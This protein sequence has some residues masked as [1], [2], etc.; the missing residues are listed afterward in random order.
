[1]GDLG[2]CDMSK[3]LFAV[4]GIAASLL[5]SGYATGAEASL[6]DLLNPQRAQNAKMERALSG[7][8]GQPLSSFIA[9]HGDPSDSVELS[10]T[11][12]SFRWHLT[13]Q[14]PGAVIPMYGMLGVMPSRQLVCDITLRASKLISDEDKPRFW[15]IDSV[16]WQGNC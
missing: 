8:V 14:G 5:L 16:A 7:Y 9:E 3:R 12:K 13:A 1:M 15:T 11:S 10:D 2:K 6:R 4:I